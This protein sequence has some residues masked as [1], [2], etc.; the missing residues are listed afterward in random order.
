MT[1][2]GRTSLRLF[3]LFSVSI[4]CLLVTSCRWTAQEERLFI[5]NEADGTVS[6]VD[7]ERAVVVA[8]VDVG[9]RP[10]GL[11]LSPDGARLYVAIG[12]EN[13][14][15]AVDTTSLEVVQRIP[16]GSDP[17]AFAVHPNGHL[18][19]SNEDE[20]TATVIDPTNGQH[21]A[22]LKVGIEPEGVAA[23]HA[24][25]WVIVTAESTSTLHFFSVPSHTPDK[26]LLVGAR[27]REAV[28]SAD[29]RWLYV[30]S[31]I[32]RE[33]AK[34]DMQTLEIAAKA[35]IE[36]PQVKPK[37]LALSRDGK[38]LYASTGSANTVLVLDTKTL[39]T[40]KV[41][42]VGRRPW[43]IALSGDGRFLYTANG[44]DNSVSVVDT[45]QQAVIKTIS[46]GQRPWTVVVD[47]R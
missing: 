47:P 36:D 44:I 3:S 20:G 17:E 26:T 7:P 31:E 25:D 22:V 14:I 4:L 24:G 41:I 40:R 8:S 16:A 12:N 30:T 6:V 13:L 29:D 18:Y 19:V 1:N 23:S 15:A 33:V 37:G 34:I 46:V 10:R 39:A 35:R 38:T 5:S 2:P 11:G 43:G 32:G 45:Q 28:F 21:L 27:P 42:P 9:S